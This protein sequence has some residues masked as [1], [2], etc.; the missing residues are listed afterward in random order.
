MDFLK[1][2]GNQIYT[3]SNK[4]VRL[5]GTC[6]GG[7]MNM[8]N[9]IN[10]YPGAEN[11]LRAIMSEELGQGKAQFFFDRL[12]DHFF[13]EDDIRFIRE[14]GAS[15]VRLALNYRH[16]ENDTDLFD[17]MEK[18]FKRLDQ[19][20]AWCEKAGIYAILD[21]H[22]APG[23]QNPDWH[24]DNST[25]HTLFWS[26]PQ[27]QD[28]FVALWTQIARRYQGRAVIAGYNLLNEPVTNAPY[29]HFSK[30][31]TPNYTVLNK[32]Y[33]RTISEMREE[34]PDHII[35]LE[36]DLYS[37]RFEGL[38]PPFTHNLVYSSHN[39]TEPGFGP[40]AYPG[41]YGRKY[42]DREAQYQMF[43][44]TEGRKF[45][46]QYDVPLWVGEFGS[47]YH[48]PAEEV[49][50]RLRA[51]D[52]QINVF[53]ETGTHWTTWTYKDVGVMGWVTLDPESEYMQ[54]IKHSL[55]AKKTL[56]VDFWATL[57]PLSPA[58]RKVNQ[59]ARLIEQ[60][61]QDAAIDPKA[62]AR[63]LRQAAQCGYTATLMQYTYAR[64]FKGISEN[65]MDRML[66]SFSF[67]QTK[68][69]QGLLDVMKKNFSFSPV[70][71]IFEQ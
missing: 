64:L 17:Y 69:N 10:G 15:V 34:D 46:V 71:Y 59:L 37:T 39:Y 6:V 23:W 36:G 20:L 57:P 43:T 50:D 35:F 40:G 11:S 25:R 48:G 30:Q 60:T 28:R 14:T 19:V 12:L 42:W 66:Q 24:C 31:Y 62:N 4:P 58:A 56:A 13:N 49:Y 18:G 67:G 2:T 16:F 21:M 26:Q 52:D 45:A 61:L 44:Q 53:E 55:Q 41:R 27:F 33:L 38:N 9:F 1:V 32:L 47:T 54:R 5:R 63:Y 22:S 7:W 8:E 3:T 70:W 65:E 51:I 29:G 68:P